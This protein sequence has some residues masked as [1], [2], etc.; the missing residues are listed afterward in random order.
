MEWVTSSP[1]HWDAVVEGRE[2]LLAPWSLFS[3]S[4]GQ[5]SPLLAL[6]PGP[7]NPTIEGGLLLWALTPAPRDSGGAL[8]SRDSGG[9]LAPR[10]SWG[11][12][13]TAAILFL[14]ILGVACFFC[15][16][17]RSRL[18]RESLPDP[19]NQSCHTAKT[20]LAGLHCFCLLI[21]AHG[22]QPAE[23][24]QQAKA[25]CC[26]LLR[27]SHFWP[28]MKV[29]C[30]TRTH[31]GHR[32]W[33]LEIAFPTG[34]PFFNRSCPHTLLL[35]LLLEQ[36]ANVQFGLIWRP[37]QDLHYG[38]SKSKKALFSILEFILHLFL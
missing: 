12:I 29:S 15:A 9:A 11:I 7:L 18:H 31:L 28:R 1:L 27:T 16:C 8:A 4:S 17:P 22:F 26:H 2:T 19:V 14:S 24:H 21:G 36:S 13:L 34:R 5:E 10:D 23:G 37:K 6:D 30:L 33:I 35:Q 25:A 20:R 38:H 32:S 3:S